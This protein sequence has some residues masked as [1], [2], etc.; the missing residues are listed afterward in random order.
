MLLQS[1][2]FSCSLEWELECNSCIQFLFPRTSERKQ[3]PWRLS[4]HQAVP[5]A[6][7][8]AS[9]GYWFAT[10]LTSA[11]PHVEICMLALAPGSKAVL[12][13]LHVFCSFHP[14]DIQCVCLASMNRRGYKQ[15]S[16]SGSLCTSVPSALLKI[17]INLQDWS[18]R[19]TCS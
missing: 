14:S 17:W 6:C 15:L 18:I 5:P 13:F 8:W 3:Q 11:L 9:V 2:L 19:F 4:V 12:L 1:C 10:A 7:A 16:T